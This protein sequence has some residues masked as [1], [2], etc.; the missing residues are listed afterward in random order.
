MN[1]IIIIIFKFVF[2]F[3][4]I[5][6]DLNIYYTIRGANAFGQWYLLYTRCY[7]FFF[8]ISNPAIQAYNDVTLGVLSDQSIKPIRLYPTI[9]QLIWKV[10][11]EMICY[12]AVGVWMDD[13][14]NAAINAH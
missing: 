6:I 5:S 12:T 3:S 1:E 14:I 11:K 10:P 8:S 4:F 7:I 13:C 9:I 2:L